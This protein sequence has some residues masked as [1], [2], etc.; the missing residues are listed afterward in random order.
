MLGSVSKVFEAL[1]ERVRVQNS[2]EVKILSVIPNRYYTLRLLG[3]YLS[4]T[5]E[6]RI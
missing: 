6:Y 5:V 4:F 2:V 1:L 3:L